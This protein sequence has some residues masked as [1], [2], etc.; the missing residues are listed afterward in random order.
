MLGTQRTSEFNLLER[1]E[2]V[3]NEAWRAPRSEINTSPGLWRRMAMRQANLPLTVTPDRWLDTHVLRSVC[4]LV[5]VSLNTKAV[6]GNHASASLFFRDHAIRRHANEYGRSTYIYSE[7]P[8][9]H[10]HILLETSEM[11]VIKQMERISRFPRP[12]VRHR[13]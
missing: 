6:S 4:G 5:H 9:I 10:R 13:N 3:G 2:I 1:P 8:S 11:H 7:E 12:F